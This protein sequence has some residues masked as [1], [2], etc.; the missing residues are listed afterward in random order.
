[1]AMKQSL[2]T[3]RVY[4]YL[5]RQ[6]ASNQWPADARIPGTRT[7]AATLNVSDRTVRKVL[8][9]A[10]EA[11]LLAVAE[12]RPATVL[13]GAGARARDILA[14]AAAEQRSRRL[15]ILLGHEF[16]PLSRAPFQ[17][18][19]ARAVTAAGEARGYRTQ[20]E[21]I[22]HDN[23]LAFSRRVMCRYHAAFVPELRPNHLAPIIDLA[24]H[25]FPVLLF[26][27]RIEGMG[28]PSL[29]TN[30]A[31]AL[32]ELADKLA[33]LG[34]R[35]MALVET[36][37]YLTVRGDEPPVASWME[38]LRRLDLHGECTMPVVFSRWSDAP[39]IFDRVLALRPRITALV[40]GPPTFLRV[41][42][43]L[44][45]FRRL[46]IPRD[47]SL[48]TLSSPRNLPLP[49]HC[50][51]IT[52]FELD[53]NRAGRCALEMIDRMLA[54]ERQPKD[55]R[56]PLNIRRTESIGPAPTSAA[57]AVPQRSGT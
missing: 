51:P 6:L 57:T 38:S 31:G 52:Y 4:D 12:R 37:L 24:E 10:R 18:R 8:R 49:P 30:D 13:P 46:R 43:E 23:Q 7:L 1:M 3:R 2:L 20:V 5:L 15:A 40:L 44:E 9:M 26:N 54:S 55:I 29:N 25:N 33:K 14:A 35:N 42:V 56:V 47:M 50:P 22:P 27:R 17:R 45:R 41:L 34:H 32:D 53:W 36:P 16:F 39:V 19:L 21:C 11:G 28:L 48:A